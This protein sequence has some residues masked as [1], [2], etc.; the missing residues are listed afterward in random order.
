MEQD[1]YI[2]KPDVIFIISPHAS[3]FEEAFSVNARPELESNFGE[4]G[5]FTTKKI[6][7]GSPEIAQQISE[8]VSSKNNN[9][10]LIGRKELDHGSSIPLFYL[11]DHLPNI[12]IL[13]FGFCSLENKE[14]LE[15]GELLKNYILD[16]NLRIAVIASADLS[17]GLTTEA[18]AGLSKTG[19]EFDEKIV[20]LL[21]TKNTIGIANMEENFVKEASECGYRSILILLG[22]TKNMNYSFRNYSYESPFGVGYLVGNFVL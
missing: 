17:H 1:L 18:P 5:D 8:K 16:T 19:K 22:I 3:L 15:F 4:F 13:P 9:L 11:T 21:E 20:E 14:H 2:A 12:K 6:W 7:Q 10:R